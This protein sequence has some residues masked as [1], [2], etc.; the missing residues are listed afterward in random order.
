MRGAKTFWASGGS[1]G[2]KGRSGG[3]KAVRRQALKENSPYKAGGKVPRKE[4]YLSG[5]GCFK[6]REEGEGEEEGGEK[7]RVR[8]EK[9][10]ESFA[11]RGNPEE[12]KCN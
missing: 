11:H 10:A 1:R 5:S 4:T 6:L 8:V 2:K 7:K 9:V 12:K 3:E